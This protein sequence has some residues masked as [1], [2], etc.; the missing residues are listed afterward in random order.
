MSRQENEKPRKRRLQADYTLSSP[1][2][3]RPE[4]RRICPLSGVQASA[5]ILCHPDPANRTPRAS[6]RLLSVRQTAGEAGTGHSAAERELD[7]L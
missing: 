4:K 7:G 5:G 1:N 3:D 6:W 2:W